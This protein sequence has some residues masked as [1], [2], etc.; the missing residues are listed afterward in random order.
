MSLAM[1]LD[2]IALLALVGCVC[3]YMMCKELMDRVAVLE[4][5]DVDRGF[6]VV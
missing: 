5:E 2:V 3:L 1:L 4:R 6:H